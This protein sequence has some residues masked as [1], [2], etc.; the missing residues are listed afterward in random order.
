MLKA[1]TNQVAELL[2]KDLNSIYTIADNSYLNISVQQALQRDNAQG[3]F[4]L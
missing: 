4:S 2:G 1:N 3:I